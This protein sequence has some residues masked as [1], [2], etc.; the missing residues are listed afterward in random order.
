MS[1]VSDPFDFLFGRL[2]YERT[3]MPRSSS[4]LRL[5]RM[6]RLLR[7]LGDPQDAAPIVHVAGTKGKGSTSAL[8]AAAL[9]ASGIKTGLFSSPHL[10]AVEERFRTDGNQI[11]TVDLANLINEIRPILERLDDDES[12][13]GHRPST[14]FE[15]TTALGLLHFA[16]A[17]AGAV[18]LEVGLGG[19]LDS[20]N[21]VR[22]AVSVLTNISF[23]HTKQLGNTLAAIAGEK[24][25]IIK[26]RRAVVS[27]VRGDEPRRV[28]EAAALLRK[29]PFRAIDI[30][31]F[32]EYIPPIQ[33]LSKPAAGIVRVRTWRT[34][35][36]GIELPLL[37]S[38]Q[39]WNAATALATLDVLG[40]RG[41][42]VSADSVRRGFGSLEW[43]ARVEVMGES[44]WLVVDGAHNV[45]AAQALAETLGSNFPHTRR[46]L[47]FG[48]SKDKDVIGQLRELLPLFDRAVA[49][50][51]LE[52]PRAVA[53]D[54]IAAIVRELSAID[55]RIAPEPA[56]ALETARAITDADSLICVTGSI[57]LA[58]EV[59]AL[60]KRPIGTNVAPPILLK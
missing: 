46:T 10:N 38:H 13:R 8:I 36:G 3:G 59:R 44:P 9:T 21:A 26:R 31:Y 11:A 54:E 2:N 7:A 57:F 39:A 22:P 4:E 12:A 56:L 20:T 25:G 16:R 60:L 30:D 6:R 5:A 18:V 29:A 49:T 28:I 14:F 32:Y 33:P 24:A 37:G 35:W 58:A 55:C 52:N 27:G 34:D 17:N 50:R 42:D 15:V 45:A 40:E 19:R 53:P 23:D 51:Y 48:A 43:P 1:E 47:V 41:I